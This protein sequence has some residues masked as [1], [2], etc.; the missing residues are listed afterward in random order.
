[1]E[2]RGQAEDSRQPSLQRRASDGGNPAGYAR[3]K[4]LVQGSAV[5]F[6][7][8]GGD[9]QID[10]SGSSGTDFLAV[11]CR[12]TEEATLPVEAAGVRRVAVRTGIVLAR[13]EG[14]LDGS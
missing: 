7:G 2:H 11:V 4:V 10:E 8:V 12:E 6:Y 3:P 13:N 5:G 1:M 9:E 14:A